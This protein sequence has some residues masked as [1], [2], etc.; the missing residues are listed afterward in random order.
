VGANHLVGLIETG[1]KTVDL[2]TQV[3]HLVFTPYVAKS[4]RLID[5]R[6]DEVG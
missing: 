1:A 6:R 2:G 5:S 4:D 3:S